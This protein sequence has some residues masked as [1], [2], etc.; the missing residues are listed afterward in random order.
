MP[1]APIL[2]TGGLGFLGSHLAAR[3]AAEGATVRILAKP[4]REVPS[5]SHEIVWAD[6]RDAEAVERAVCGA[7]SVVHLASNFRQGGADRAEAWAVNVEGTR[8]VLAA[9][10]RQGVRRLVHCST[11]GVHGSV[12]EVPA[13]EETPFRPL[14]LYQETKLAAEQEVWR[15][16]RATGLPVTVLR[17]VS[18]IGPGD[19][20]MLKLFRLIERRRFVMVGSGDTLIQL[21]YVDDVVDGFLLALRKERAVGEAFIV[22][23]DE[24]LPLRDL[25][26]LIAAELGVP[27]P[28]L[29]VPL[30][31]VLLLAELCERLFGPLGIEPPLHR[32]R[33]SF[34]RYDRAFSLEKARRVLGFQPRTSLRDAVRATIAWYRHQGWL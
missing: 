15:H 10:S 20:K 32:P 8:N 4:R 11:I 31:P 14:D 26:R 21:A 1:S 33:V 6:I 25:V 24:F 3:L 29:R 12:L 13:H 28:R 22:G 30:R 17:P 19:R 16:Y 2:V 9:C 34:F 7:E 23:G 18:L 27:P 5:S